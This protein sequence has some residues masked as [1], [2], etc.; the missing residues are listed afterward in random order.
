M[1]LFKPFPKFH[2]GTV[3]MTATKM[4]TDRWIY[5]GADLYQAYDTEQLF[6]TGADDDVIDADAEMSEAEKRNQ[7]KN[8]LYCLLPP[9]Y[10]SDQEKEVIRARFQRIN[11]KRRLVVSSVAV[12][13]GLAITAFFFPSIIPSFA[14]EVPVIEEPAPEP[15]D[16]QN[17]Q[18]ELP[19]SVVEA[20]APAVQGQ[21]QQPSGFVAAVP[22]AAPEPVGLARYL[23]WEVR[24]YSVIGGDLVRAEFTNGRVIEDL[25]TV[26]RQGLSVSYHSPRAIMLAD[27]SGLSVVLRM[28]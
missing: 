9:A 6:H 7:E 1:W 22:A 20:T 15:V 5:R 4:I 17:F 24:S 12:F 2:T 13:L 14:D 8:G 23:S 28:Y 10:F 25:L 3:R 11:K 16:L 27:A 19:Q 26:R 21:G 18:L